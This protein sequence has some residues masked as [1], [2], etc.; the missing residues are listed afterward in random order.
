MKFNQFR[1]HKEAVMQKIT[2]C[3]WFDDN[4]EEAVNFYVSIFENAK[5]KQVAYYGKAG[6]EAANRTEGSVMTMIFELDGQEFMALNGGPAFKFS[7]A[8]SLM[9]D[10]KTQEEVDRFWDR[11]SEG[12]QT[13][14]CGWL[15]DKFGVSWQI[16]PTV[17]ME[18]IQDEDQ[19]KADRVMSAMVKMTKIEIEPLK[20][21]Y[22]QD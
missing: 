5:I 7:P 8:I 2:P 4:I 21:A 16:V 19:K 3:L 22:N 1:S 17:L 18:M 15:T 6:A 9:V 12:G 13:N 14:V 11:L 20:R 10:C